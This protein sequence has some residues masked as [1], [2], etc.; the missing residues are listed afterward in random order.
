M[1]I[2]VISKKGCSNCAILKRAL[3]DKGIQYESLDYDSLTK[4]QKDKHISNSRKAGSIGLPIVIMDD[5]YTNFHDA[6]AKLREE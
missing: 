4:E 2:T 6:M 5:K 3:E 1:G